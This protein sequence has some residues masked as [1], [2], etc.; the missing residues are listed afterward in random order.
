MATEIWL[1]KYDGNNG[2]SMVYKVKVFS[3][4]DWKYA[5]PVSPMP[6]PEEDGKEN[7]LV[8]MEGNTHALNLSFI[9]K[10]EATDNAGIS[11]AG[12]NGYSGASKSIFE[13]LKWMSA[14]EA[15]DSSGGGFIGRHIY[16]E[17]DICIIEDTTGL[18]LA[19]MTANTAVSTKSEF[20]PELLDTTVSGE[21]IPVISGLSLKMNGYV[22]NI[23][24]RT[25]SSQPAT[26]QGT[27][28]FI[29]GE[30]AGGHNSKFPSKPRSFKVMTPSI[31]GENTD[32][33][34]YLTWR[35]PESSGQIGSTITKYDIAHR[36]AD[37]GT[38]F[39][40]QTPSPLTQTNVMVISLQPNTLY[41]F[42]VRGGNAEGEGRFCYTVSKK[43][44]TL[45]STA[46]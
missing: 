5:S 24:F 25:S 32:T 19:D 22:R 46:P 10:N 21:D 38:E 28:E 1:R 26:L 39:K 29:E 16:D 8:K 44:K 17:F 11:C 27:I 13:Q 2:I 4:I 9:I 3:Q 14:S 33:K 20:D 41:D 42:K 18:D 45:G 7:I 43:T 31:S 30:V 34:M 23:S 12:R 15:E 40:I 35:A 37:G 36:V 6:L